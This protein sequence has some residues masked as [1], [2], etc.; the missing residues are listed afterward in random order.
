MASAPVSI[1]GLAS[2]LNTNQ[3][4]QELISADSGVMNQMQQQIQTDQA[5]NAA[6]QAVET[7]TSALQT[8]AFAL[9][10]D[11]TVKG[12]LANSSDSSVLSAQAGAG[13]AA[14]TY[15]VTVNQ[16]ATATSATSWGSIGQPVADAT[17][18][19]SSANTED[20]ITTG[21]FTLT[22]GNSS[23]AQTPYQIA[24]DPGDTWQN[25]F[26]RIN[27]ATGGLVTASLSNNK[28]V[29][30]TSSSVTS[31][32]MGNQD[33][34]SN[35]LH[36]IHMDTAQFDPAT[37]SVTSG[38]PVG[39]AQTSATLANAR[40]A[41]ALTATQGDFKINGVDIP[42]NSATD[43]VNSIVNAIN[44]SN[45][46]VVAAY[47]SADDKMVVTSKNTGSQ[48]IDFQDVNGN[49][50]QA[51]RVDKGTQ[52]TGQDASITIAGMNVDPS[53]NQPQPIY[54]TSNSFQ[55]VLPGVVINATQTGTS[56]LS[57][58]QD[59]DTLV[60]A[61][62]DFVTQF[63][64]TIDMINTQ[65][66]QGGP[67]AFNTDLSSL[68]DQLYNI[69]QTPVS[70]LTGSPSSL[71]D[72]GISIPDESTGHLALDQKTLVAALQAN[73][74]AV[75]AIFQQT[76]PNPSDPSSPTPVGIAQMMN[77][78]LQQTDGPDGIFQNEQNSTNTLVASLNSSI[79]QQQ[80]KLKNEQTNLQ[81]QFAAMEQAI[82][83][84]KNQD[85]MMASQLGTTAATTSF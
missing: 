13:A 5:N 46:G 16:L 67:L 32:V 50:L 85:G 61:V 17:T 43:T 63:N 68:S 31:M 64:S 40:L 44:S 70:G 73:P 47:S 41:T 6:F 22:L 69:V 39:V 71:M 65:I 80:D 76:L 51:L 1:S 26:D 55:N 77:A 66:G 27:T 7:N 37:S 36:E 81:Q 42:W 72:L 24:V 83:T 2:G 49:L 30:S 15:D 12:M 56:T 21:N 29:L 18:T 25:V 9:T 3:I 58:S 34:T 33:D 20:P 53:T 62:N 28:V 8:S 79:Q 74:N 45:A 11:S 4:V 38:Q 52:I 82:S 78:F 35:F 59:S 54:S 10:E 19:L 57:V 75:A 60:K 48:N 23:G 84:M 14:G